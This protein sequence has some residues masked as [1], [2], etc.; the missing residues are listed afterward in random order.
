MGEVFS[1]DNEAETIFP[2][3]LQKTIDKV[4]TLQSKCACLLLRHSVNLIFT[5]DLKIQEYLTS[6]LK[7][8]RKY[9]KDKVI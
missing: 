5:V 1:M 8:K 6:N 4:F 3:G 2:N 9:H 7:G